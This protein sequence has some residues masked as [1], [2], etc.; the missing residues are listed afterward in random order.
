MTRKKPF[1]G[2]VFYHVKATGDSRRCQIFRT[3]I[4][5]KAMKHIKFFSGNGC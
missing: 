2:T 5:R 1:T 4:R 3:S